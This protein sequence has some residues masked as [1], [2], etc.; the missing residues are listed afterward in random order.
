MRRASLI[1][2][3]MGLVATMAATPRALACSICGCGDPLL[4]ASDPAAI[5]G[6][7]RLQL[8]TEYLRIDAGTDGQ[9]GH[10]DQLTQWSYRLNAVYRPV[11]RVSFMISAPLIDKAIRTVGP[12]VSQAGSDL[13]GFGDLELGARYAFWRSI[14]FANRRVQEVALSLGSM[15]PTGANDARTTDEAGDVVPVDPH[16]IPAP[17]PRASHHRDLSDSTTKRFMPD[18]LR[19]VS[20]LSLHAEPPKR[21]YR[22]DRSLG[23]FAWTRMWTTSATPMRTGPRSSSSA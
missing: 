12:G 18:S 14:D 16:G 9:P 8:D 5:T 17:W 2:S 11:S 4:A 7:L 20:P 22:P 19:L 10:T 23:A 15:L 1:A 6:T 13:V 3:A 21:S